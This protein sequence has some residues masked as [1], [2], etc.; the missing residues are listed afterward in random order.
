MWGWVT[1]HKQKDEVC[2]VPQRNGSGKQGIGFWQGRSLER[3]PVAPKNLPARGQEGCSS[4]LTLA[5]CQSF[6]NVKQNARGWDSLSCRE[7]LVEL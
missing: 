2:P 5:G 4:A 3:L 1:P 7:V 6:G